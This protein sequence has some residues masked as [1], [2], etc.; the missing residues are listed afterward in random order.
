MIGRIA[1]EYSGEVLVGAGTVLDAETA[2]AVIL[3]GASFIVAPNLNLDVIRMAKRYDRIVVPGALTPTEI[4]TAWEAGA[5]LVKI[6]PAS[7]LGPQYI[8]DL[9]GPLPQIAMIPT[10]GVTLE[11]AGQYIKAGAKA[12]AT[13]SNLVNPKWLK[14]GKLDEITKMAA[15]FVAAVHEARSGK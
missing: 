5:D 15:A 1:G 2:R 3:A 4:L 8:K 12:I 14:E 11:N 13:G 7:S 10:G 6:F 9:L